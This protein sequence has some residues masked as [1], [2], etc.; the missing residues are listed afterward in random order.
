[1]I[2]A[3]VMLLMVFLGLFFGPELYTS[4]TGNEIRVMGVSLQ[5]PQIQAF[6]AS[7]IA[8]FQ[9]AIILF[10]VLDRI[11]D[12]IKIII[13]PVAVLLP[14]GAFLLAVYRTFA[15]IIMSFLPQEL[16]GAAGN[17]PTYIIQASQDGS[18]TTGILI[19]L[20][21]MMLFLLAYRTLTAESEQV[22]ALKAELA[23][24]RKALR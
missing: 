9:F 14:L 22:K 18:L 21:T 23:R 3:F 8:F 2:N 20:G 15:P 24:M 17:N 5:S 16:V 13:K 7:G 4:A 10:S 19:T 11:A 1:M 12:T 6:L